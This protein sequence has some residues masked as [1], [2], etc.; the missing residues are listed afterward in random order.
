MRKRLMLIL[1]ALVLG[2][3]IGRSHPETDS[4]R[5]MQV[6]DENRYFAIQKALTQSK[7][8]PSGPQDKILVDAIEDLMES[9][10]T[11]PFRANVVRILRHLQFEKF[12]LADQI[13]LVDIEKM[14]L[15][16]SP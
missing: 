7:D 5:E 6:R 8:L 2:G 3:P 11:T 10:P 1:A 13:R 12:E 9:P 14:F 4:N 15:G 16:Y